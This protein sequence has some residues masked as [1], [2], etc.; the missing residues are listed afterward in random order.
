MTGS[1][2]PLCELRG[3]QLRFPK[4]KGQPQ[5]VLEDIR[6]E[7]R[8][9]E[10]LSIIG[11]NDCG[12][13][14]LLRVL[15]GL[16]EPT[17]GELR[18]RG[19][20][21][22]GLN[23]GM[24]MV[25]QSFALFPWM[26]VEENVR[27]V[28]RARDLPEE[29]VRLRAHDAIRRVG[30]E[31]FE[32]AFPRELSRGTK[33]RVGVARALAVDPEVL[34]MD[35][36]FSQVDALTAEALRAE[37]LDIWADPE[38]NPSS[39]VLVSHSIREALLMADRV[40][41]MDGPPGT[42]RAVVDVPLPRPRDT[43]SRDFQKMVDRIHDIIT[44]AELPD[45]QVNGPAHAPE[46]DLVEPLPPV[47]SADILGLLEFLEAQGGAGD[48]FTV[49]QATQVSFQQMILTV[50][51]AE[52]LE[53]VETPRREVRLT[54]LG[55]RFVQADMD[56]R[57]DLWRAQLLELRLFRVVHELIELRE[58]ELSRE[59]LVQEIATRLP[60]EDPEQT[61]DT[62]VAWGRFGELFAYREDQEA[63]TFE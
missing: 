42:L 31:G 5:R 13:S 47:N 18:Y 61:F 46:E 38:R 30:L 32:E 56:Q 34:V 37:L 55:H 23:P 45:I 27:V 58:G 44:S 19:E 62:V 53:L 57:K 33:Q 21:L 25:F 63:L 14:S 28:L 9:K 17:K 35:E 12:K 15:A 1:S 24:A 43:R 6:L 2:T 52:T 10:I 11:P 39:I 8:P 7:V 29:E 36:P 3:V 26:T 22:E 50:K 51:A 20:K 48:L 40:V 60:M 59:E 16:T 54:E 49:A 41:V 4:P